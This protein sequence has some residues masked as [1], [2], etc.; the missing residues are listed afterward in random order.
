MHLIQNNFESINFRKSRNL[1]GIL[2]CTVS[3]PG[4]A[5]IPSFLSISISISKVTAENTIQRAYTWSWTT[6]KI[7]LSMMDVQILR[8]SGDVVGHSGSPPLPEMVSVSTNLSELL[9]CYIS[10]FYRLRTQFSVCDLYFSPFFYPNHCSLSM[11]WRSSCIV[12]IQSSH[13]QCSSLSRS[14][15]ILQMVERVGKYRF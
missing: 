12:S 9:L 3:C 13:Y 6:T 1:G 7:V 8:T 2:S 11:L 15:N 10:L 14:G 4:K 5:A